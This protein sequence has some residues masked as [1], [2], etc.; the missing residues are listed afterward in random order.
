MGIIISILV[1][2][3]IIRKY[4]GSKI[5]RYMY[6]VTILETARSLY[7]DTYTIIYKDKNKKINN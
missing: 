5:K 3:I 4:M 2:V 7:T 6:C 1:Y